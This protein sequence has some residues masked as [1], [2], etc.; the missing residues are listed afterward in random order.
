[1][2][3][4][5]TTTL[6]TLHQRLSQSIQ[7]IVEEDTTINIGAGVTVVSTSLNKWDRGKDDYFNDWWVYITEGN[8]IGVER[9]VSDYATSTGTLTVRGGNLA[10]EAGAVTFRLSRYS[11]AEKL[12][13]LNNAIR[14]VYPHLYRSCYDTSLIANNVLPNS[15]FTD[16]SLTTVPDWFTLNSATAA[17]ITTAGLKW[18]N[19]SSVMVTASAGNGGIYCH[20]N[21]YPTLLDLMGTTITFRSWVYPQAAN[22][23]FIQIVTGKADGTAQTL[24]STTACPAAKWTLVELEDQSI[25]DNIISIRFEFT[26]VTNTKYA[27]FDN[28]RVYGMTMDEYLLPIDFKNGTVQKAHV[29]SSAY[30]ED[31]CDD[32]RPLGWEKTYFQII[33]DGTYKWIKLPF[34][35]ETGR[36]IKLEGYTSLETLS[37]STDTISLDGEKVDL[38]I[39]YAAMDLFGRNEG[40]PASEDV[41]RFQTNYGRW[42]A[43]Y[44]ELLG[45][46]GMMRPSKSM[47]LRMY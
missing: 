34:L 20:S 36:Q 43:K 46:I 18:G 32:L 16:W 41:G 38:L 37:T 28:A 22:D 45:R 10:A 19:G 25:N 30:S 7:D 39:A 24:T 31:P 3:D 6:L 17:K 15:H 40:V 2:E 44:Y 27:Y 9:E 35:Y 11:W 5:M 47:N 8:N 26:V 23:A 42:S 4:K 13:S 29:Q 12:L 14:E 33:D 1:M 21:T